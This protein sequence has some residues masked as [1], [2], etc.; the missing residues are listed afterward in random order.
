MND[1]TD[2]WGVRRSLDGCDACEYYSGKGR[3]AEMGKLMRRRA[4]DFHITHH[5]EV[6]QQ[7][8]KRNT[9]VPRPYCPVD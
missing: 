3:Q 2:V 9:R 6:M 1:D 4:S 5:E 7:E 8:Q